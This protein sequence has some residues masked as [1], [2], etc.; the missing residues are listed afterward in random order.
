MWILHYKQGL[1]SPPKIHHPAEKSRHGD[2]RWKF[3]PLK[4][5]SFEIFDKSWGNRSGRIGMSYSVF[6][7]LGLEVFVACFCSLSPLEEWNKPFLLEEKNIQ[8]R[9]FGTKM[10]HVQWLPLWEITYPPTKRHFWVDDFLAFSR[11]VGYVSSE[12][13]LCWR[14]LLL[15]QGTGLSCSGKNGGNDLSSAGNWC[16]PESIA[17]K[18]KKKLV[19]GFRGGALCFR[20]IF[21][22]F[23]ATHFLGKCIGFMVCVFF[24]GYFLKGCIGIWRPWKNL[25]AQR[26]P[27]D[28]LSNFLKVGGPFKK[29][30]P[31][32]LQPKQGFLI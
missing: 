26:G 1:P 20:C 27:T 21:C 3:T 30:R 14:L 23:S 24:L 15:H 10:S 2:L 7:T 17:K 32:S 5:R 9:P 6:Q 22:L 25:Q 12:C 16:C 19:K 29:R 11:L 18:Q 4:T 28:D 31:N 8:Q 13:S